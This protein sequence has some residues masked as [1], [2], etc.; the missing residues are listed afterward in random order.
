VLLPAIPREARRGMTRSSAGSRSR[1]ARHPFPVSPLPPRGPPIAHDAVADVKVIRPRECS[2][3]HRIQQ[4]AVCSRAAPISARSGASCDRAFP[5][6][7]DTPHTAPREPR[8][9]PTPTGCS[10]QQRQQGTAHGRRDNSC[11]IRLQPGRGCSVLHEPGGWSMGQMGTS[12][13]KQRPCRTLNRSRRRN[14]SLFEAL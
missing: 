13:T 12:R 7:F 2:W 9:G 5:G 1:R 8:R 4:S 3:T 14:F 11:L 6:A 10:F